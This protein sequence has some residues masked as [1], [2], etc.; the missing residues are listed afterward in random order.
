MDITVTFIT[1]QLKWQE[2]HDVLIEPAASNG[3]K[4]PSVVRLSKIATLD[5]SIVIGKLGALSTAELTLIDGGLIRLFQIKQLL[6][7]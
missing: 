6:L 1:T 2:Q 4:R 7:K 3:L 5:K